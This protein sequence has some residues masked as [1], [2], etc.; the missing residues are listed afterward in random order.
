MPNY[1]HRELLCL[2]DTSSSMN[3]IREEAITTLYSQINQAKSLDQSVDITLGFFSSELTT[4]RTSLAA[5]QLPSLEDFPKFNNGASSLFDS[6]GQLL[7]EAGERFA[8]LNDWERPGVISVI[9]ASDGVDSSSKL[10][11]KELIIDMINHQRDV[12]NWQF[13]FIGSEPYSY[14]KAVGISASAGKLVRTLTIVE[15]MH[16]LNS[17]KQLV[18]ASKIEDSFKEYFSEKGTTAYQMSVPNLITISNYIK[19]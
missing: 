10:Y 14:R 12:Y 1:S 13:L 18:A 2:L 5:L 8:E 15:R 9:I 17:R 16:H 4:F 6:I 7:S 19:N 11:T 3:T